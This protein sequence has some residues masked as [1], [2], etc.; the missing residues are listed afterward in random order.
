M[1]LS[2]PWTPSSN[3][4]TPWSSQTVNSTGYQVE[5]LLTSPGNILLENRTSKFLLEDRSS[6]LKQE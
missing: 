4:S 6:K 3:N 2:T 1:P 5:N